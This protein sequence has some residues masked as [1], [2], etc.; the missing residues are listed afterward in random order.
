MT[1]GSFIK[2]ELISKEDIVEF[3]IPKQFIKK[4]KQKILLKNNDTNKL[5]IVEENYM[6]RFALKTKNKSNTN[7]FLVSEE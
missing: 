1:F 5:V 2:D 4:G 7:N 3:N 6:K